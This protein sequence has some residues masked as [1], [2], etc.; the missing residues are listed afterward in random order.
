MILPFCQLRFE[1]F[2]GLRTEPVYRISTLWPP[3]YLKKAAGRGAEADDV[4]VDPVA[5]EVLKFSCRYNGASCKFVVYCFVHMGGVF[6]RPFSIS[7]CL[8]IQ[9]VFKM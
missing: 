8:C 5:G 2:Y 6:S 3:G 7:G 4:G 9:T 1:L